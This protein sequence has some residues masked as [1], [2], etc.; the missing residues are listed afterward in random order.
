MKIRYTKKKKH[1]GRKKQTVN[2]RGEAIE[3]TAIGCNEGDDQIRMKKFVT[4]FGISILPSS[5]L[6]LLGL[7]IVAVSRIS[8]ELVGTEKRNV[9]G[10]PMH[11]VQLTQKGYIQVRI[12]CD[13]ISVKTQIFSVFLFNTIR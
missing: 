1:S 7:L 2:F 11:S 5:S 4:N 12:A 9:R 6:I 8:S 13:E 3:E 10:T